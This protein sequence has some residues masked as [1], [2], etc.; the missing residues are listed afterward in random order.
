MPN[1]RV[2]QFHATNLHDLMGMEGGGS[3]TNSFS[4]RVEGPLTL[5]CVTCKNTTTH[6]LHWKNRMGRL[7]RRN[8]NSSG[9]CAS[10]VRDGFG[11]FI[12]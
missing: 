10:Q 4:T 9:C 12:A 5:T 7:C 6:M 1:L 3:R 11:G 8:N 2:L